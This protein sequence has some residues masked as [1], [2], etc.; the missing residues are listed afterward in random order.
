MS[1]ERLAVGEL[2]TPEEWVALLG[3]PLP[4]LESVPAWSPYGEQGYET[5]RVTKPRFMEVYDTAIQ[6][7]DAK[8]SFELRDCEGGGVIHICFVGDGELT[9]MK[10]SDS[11]AQNLVVTSDVQLVVG[12]TWEK[13]LKKPRFASK[14]MLG[15]V[16]ISDR[17]SLI[18][19]VG[20]VSTP[21]IKRIIVTKG[22]ER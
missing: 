2:H 12:R 5:D 22:D 8:P 19:Q 18:T 20:N 1:D 10:R 9:I 3:L 15:K 21:K 17:L 13:A 6:Q 14:L 7:T 4:V 11:P 16:T